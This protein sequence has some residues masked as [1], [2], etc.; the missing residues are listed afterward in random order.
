MLSCDS[1]IRITMGSWQVFDSK[2][3]HSDLIQCK[4]IDMLSLISY[5][6]CQ[7]SSFIP[8]VTACAEGDCVQVIRLPATSVWSVWCM[9]NEDIITGS[10]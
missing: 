1:P 9:E 4:V 5:T 2:V 7:S 6:F 8:S 3:I 10:R